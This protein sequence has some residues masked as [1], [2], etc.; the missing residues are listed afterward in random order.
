MR[1]VEPAIKFSPRNG[2]KGPPQ[3]R[4]PKEPDGPRA[5]MDRFKM[6]QPNGNRGKDP[7]WALKPLNPFR[8]GDPVINQPSQGP[9]RCA[10]DRGPFSL[11]FP[12]RKKPDHA[13]GSFAN[14]HQGGEPAQGLLEEQRASR[15]RRRWAITPMVNQGTTGQAGRHS[16]PRRW[17]LR[18]LKHWKASA[19]AAESG[20]GVK[21]WGRWSKAELPRFRSLGCRLTSQTV[22]QMVSQMKPTGS[23]RTIR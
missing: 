6:D 23:A 10:A 7:R 13:A 15:G 20:K 4:Q 12:L 21:G 14:L 22:R 2:N 18:G 16:S 11:G 8:L 19:Q 9:V 17:P 5:C 3:T 1:N